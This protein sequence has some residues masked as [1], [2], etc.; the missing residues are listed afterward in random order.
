MNPQFGKFSPEIRTQAGA[1][2]DIFTPIGDMVYG[3]PDVRVF[4]REEWLEDRR[5]KRLLQ[6]Q[7]EADRKKREAWNVSKEPCLR[8][9][10]PE[11]LRVAIYETWKSHPALQKRY[12]AAEYYRIRIKMLEK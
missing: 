4:N 12:T 8:K 9:V 1:F 11:D 5:A 6:A 3:V 2:L 10:T 7:Y